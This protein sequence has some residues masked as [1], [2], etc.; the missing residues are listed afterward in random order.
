MAVRTNTTSHQK[1]WRHTYN[2]FLWEVKFIEKLMNYVRK[3]RYLRSLLRTWSFRLFSTNNWAKTL[4]T[5]Y[6]CKSLIPMGNGYIGKNSF[7]HNR[8]R[9]YWTQYLNTFYLFHLNRQKL[10][11]FLN[12]FFM[13]NKCQLS[14][15]YIYYQ[16]IM[17]RLT[18]VWK[19]YKYF[20]SNI[21]KHTLFLYGLH[22]WFTQKYPC[23]R[24]SMFFG[25]YQT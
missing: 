1:D 22:I 9:T 8:P 3:L 20:A 12:I 6:W 25:G 7:S 4:A 2:S 23:L 18:W 21:P 19:N 13:E 16:P 17:K 5:E 10:K 15:F 24:L 11:I 14:N